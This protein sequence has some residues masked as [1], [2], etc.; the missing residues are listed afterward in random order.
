GKGGEDGTVPRNGILDSRPQRMRYTKIALLIFGC[1]LVLGL[2][3]IAA[4]IRWLGRAASSLMAFGIAAIPIG[5]IMD[6]RRM[7]KAAKPAPRRRAR[8]PAGRTAS[9]T[10]KSGRSKR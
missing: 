7:A 3:V 9:R 4:E 8:A 6:W 5:M 2:V 10:R 1:G